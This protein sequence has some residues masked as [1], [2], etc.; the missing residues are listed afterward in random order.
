[1]E[2]FMKNVLFKNLF[3][4]LA[5][6]GCSEASV[7]ADPIPQ[8]PDLSGEIVTQVQLEQ[9]KEYVLWGSKQI[10]DDG[11][12][13]FLQK[14]SQSEGEI[15]FTIRNFGCFYGC[16]GQMLLNI[17][18]ELNCVLPGPVHYDEIQEDESFVSI[19]SELAR[20]P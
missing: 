19:F 18:Y 10:D 9:L 12:R 8:Y 6:C 20:L 16:T 17:A 1:M 13:S 3:L 5:F 4:L 15:F 14:L 11:V 7:T 2:N